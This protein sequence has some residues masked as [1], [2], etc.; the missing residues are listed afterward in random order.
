MNEQNGSDATA[1]GDILQATVAPS[2]A[3]DWHELEAALRQLID[4]DGR[5]LATARRAGQ[6]I[7]ENRVSPTDR[8]RLID[9]M[10]Q[11]LATSQE[12]HR[13]LEALNPPTE[14]ASLSPMA[15][16]SGDSLAA[17]PE[18]GRR[19]RPKTPRVRL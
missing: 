3:D 7:N 8:L 12:A 15:G 11:L 19:R 13:F 17:A 5:A 2:E 14:A 10:N 6:V 1:A 16:T 4:V 9:G 18:A